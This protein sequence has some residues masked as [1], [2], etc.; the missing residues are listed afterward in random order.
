MPSV[1]LGMFLASLRLEYFNTGSIFC[2]K[3]KA[4]DKDDLYDTFSQST[5]QLFPFRCSVSSKK[6]RKEESFKLVLFK[7]ASATSGSM[8][9]VLHCK[10]LHTL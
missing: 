4:A 1:S 3:Y 10:H 6:I 8:E 7:R 2:G 9:Q 5:G